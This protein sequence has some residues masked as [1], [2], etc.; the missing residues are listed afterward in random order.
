MKIKNYKLVYD[1]SNKVYDVYTDDLLKLVR[2]NSNGCYLGYVYLMSRKP[3]WRFVARDLTDVSSG[4]ISPYYVDKWV[5]FVKTKKKVAETKKK[6]A[7]RLIKGQ[8][9]ILK[10]MKL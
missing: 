1:S 5:K 9:K 4:G 3:H 10:E 6:A 7:K 2:D 8:N